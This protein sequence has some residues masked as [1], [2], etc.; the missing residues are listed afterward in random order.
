MERKNLL[1]EGIQRRRGPCLHDRKTVEEVES[2]ERVTRREYNEEGR[3]EDRREYVGKTTFDRQIPPHKERGIQF[4]LPL[5]DSK[6]GEFSLPFP[7]Q[8]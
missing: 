1:M 6:R 4:T 7:S 8:V 3:R 5:G 2:G